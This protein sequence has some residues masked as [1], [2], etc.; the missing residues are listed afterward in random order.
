MSVERQLTSSFDCPTP[1]IPSLDL[2]EQA[3]LIP[4]GKPDTFGATPLNH[5]IVHEQQQD[6]LAGLLELAEEHVPVGIPDDIAA[7]IRDTFT[8][9][10]YKRGVANHEN[11]LSSLRS[12][13]EFKQNELLSDMIARA[14]TGHASPA[15]ILLVR[16]ALGIRSA[17]LACLTHPYGDK[18]E[19]LQTMRDVVRQSVE[20]LGGVYTATPDVR[21]RVKGV[22]DETSLAESHLIPEITRDIPF[23]LGVAPREKQWIPDYTKGLFMT[24]KRTLGTMPDGTV[25]RE[26]T[27]FIL[28]I[29]QVASP[30]QMARLSQLDPYDEHWYD[31]ILDTLDLDGMVGP[32]L[33]NDA[34]DI[35][36]PVSST[37]YAF[38]EQTAAEI[39][40]KEAH[41]RELRRAELQQHMEQETPHLLAALNRAAAI[42]A[43]G[44]SVKDIDGMLYIGPDDEF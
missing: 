7:S 24:R 13:D 30:E 40:A 28:R 18:I 4:R 14:E 34:F 5:A 33:A 15:E 38:N 17:E 37:I 2:L 36:V 3:F 9:R 23:M 26:R 27:S 42:R 22:I 43:R 10:F 8:I 32:L 29:D 31:K 1:E 6:V 39:A 16:N 12:P 35:V 25:I 44:G 11:Y 21:Y 20:T 19:V 41:E